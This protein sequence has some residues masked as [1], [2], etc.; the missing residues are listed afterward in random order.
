MYENIRRPRVE[1]IQKG[2]FENGDTWHL[3]DGE[4][5]IARDKAMRA[6]D[7]HNKMG[8]QRVKVKSPL[9]WS[10]SDFQPWL[11]SHGAIFVAEKALQETM[12]TNGQFEIQKKA[13]F[14]IHKYSYSL[15]FV[16]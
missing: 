8:S 7:Y 10:D 3:P 16:N 1:W 11:Y 13:K 6:A 4:E 15:H 14:Q 9:Q 5:Q 12:N 2:S